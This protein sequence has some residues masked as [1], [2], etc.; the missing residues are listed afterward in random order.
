MSNF[1]CEEAR[2]KIMILS[3]NFADIVFKLNGT[4]KSTAFFILSEIFVFVKIAVALT[5]MHIYE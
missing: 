4:I 1:K 5:Y 3:C 2:L